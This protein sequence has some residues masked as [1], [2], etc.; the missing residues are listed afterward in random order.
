MFG[1]SLSLGAYCLICPDT[2]KTAACRGIE[3][4]LNVLIPSL[5]VTMAMS[6]LLISCGFISSFGRIISPVSR[7]IFAIDGEFFLIFLLS[8]IAGYPVGAKLLKTQLDEGRLGREGAKFLSWVCFGSGG[9]FIFGCASSDRKLGWL[10]LLS[11]F[12][13]N[14]LML[15]LLRPL[16]KKHFDAPLPEK[17]PVLSGSLLIEAVTSAGRSMFGIC[18]CVIFFSVIS[19]MLT[20]SGTAAA[21]LDITALSGLSGAGVPLITG[22]LSF[23]GICVFLQISAIFR[24]KISVLPLIPARLCAGLLS[25]LICRLLLPPFAYGDTAVWAGS[26]SIISSS[27][28]MPSILLIFMILFVMAEENKKTADVPRSEE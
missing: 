12:L 4:C 8:Q 24:E 15:F 13:S 3:R 6:G 20:V 5:F 19:E 26:V 23:G 11:T 25:F 2:A 7:R 9:A 10:M 21:F 17:D 22:L 28:P 18:C 1:L 27:S 14:M 16:L